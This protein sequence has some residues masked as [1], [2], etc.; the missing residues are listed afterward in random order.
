MIRDPRD[1]VVSNFFQK[2]YRHSLQFDNIDE[3]N[4]DDY[5][6]LASHKFPW[7]R[8]PFCNQLRKKSKKK[9]NYKN[10]MIFLKK[11]L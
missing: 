9:N 7:K 11:K 8:E 10:K 6:E 3:M 5:R 2:R 1:A 4:C